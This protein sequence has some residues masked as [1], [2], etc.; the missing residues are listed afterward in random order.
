MRLVFRLLSFP[1][2]SE[3]GEKKE[4]KIMSSLGSQNADSKRK[5]NMSRKKT[6]D[7]S[8]IIQFES[9]A[10]NISRCRWHWYSRWT[11]DG[12]NIYWIR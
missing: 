9:P 12:D 5:M 2:V 3:D 4:K 1:H 6:N 7:A 10:Q 11:D 8:R